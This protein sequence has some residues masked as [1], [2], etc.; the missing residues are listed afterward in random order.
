MANADGIGV[1]TL[2]I[3]DLH[4]TAPELFEACSGVR[5]EALTLRERSRHIEADEIRAAFASCNGDREVVCNALGISKTTLWRKLNGTASR[6]LK[7]NTWFERV[8]L[9]G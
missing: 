3:E 1:R 2:T 9:C 8:H 5:D 7:F 6:K 4:S